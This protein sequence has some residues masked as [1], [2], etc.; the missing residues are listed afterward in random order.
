M[1]VP[2]GWGGIGW[3]SA[4]RGVGAD[5][6]MSHNTS[7]P[8]PAGPPGDPDPSLIDVVPGMPVV[9]ITVW[10]TPAGGDPAAVTDRLAYRL[11]AAYTDPGD[12][13]VDLTDTPT[14]AAAAVTGDRHHVQARTNGG[15]AVVVVATTPASGRRRPRSWRGL[16]GGELPEITDWF[17]DDLRDPDRPPGTTTVLVPTL[18]VGTGLVTL[19]VAV[20][21]PH[22][23]PHTHTR[24]LTGLLAAAVAILRPG[25]CLAFVATGGAAGYGTLVAAARTA[26]LRY[27]QHIVAVRAEVAADE[28]VY[29]ATPTDLAALAGDGTHASV[30]TDVLVFTTG[31]HR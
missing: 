20:W 5:P 22:P 30:H 21:P 8:V 12:T 17:G 18:P 3:V 7:S 6:L 11:L 26:G 23:D 19:V 24:A 28:F 15:G 2:A 1:F 14:L 29:H 27:L 31:S 10:R 9:P 13:V 4:V 25:G 16:A